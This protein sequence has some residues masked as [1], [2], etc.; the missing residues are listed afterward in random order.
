MPVNSLDHEFVKP[1][2]YLIQK[3]LLGCKKIFMSNTECWFICIKNH[4]FVK[5]NS[6]I[7]RKLLQ[8][9]SNIACGF[10]KNAH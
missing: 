2:F 9:S 3:M 6:L 7:C 5:H 4:G 1:C 8:K 10:D